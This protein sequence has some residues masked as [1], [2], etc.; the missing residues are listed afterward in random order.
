MKIK[1]TYERSIFNINVQIAS[2]KMA[3]TRTSRGCWGWSGPGRRGCGCGRSRWDAQFCGGTNLHSR[4]DVVTHI[5]CCVAATNSPILAQTASQTR[6]AKRESVEPQS[7]SEGKG[8]SS[9]RLSESY[10]ISFLRLPQ[11]QMATL[12]NSAN[13]TRRVLLIGSQLYV[14]TV[15]LLSTNKGNASETYIHAVL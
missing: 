9:L 10:T 5:A 13:Q 3:V 12:H 14:R 6:E 15:Y 8:R 11:Q 1:V 4:H 7:P 2:L